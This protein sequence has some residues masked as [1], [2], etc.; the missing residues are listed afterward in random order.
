MVGTTPLELVLSLGGTRRGD[1][2]DEEGATGQGQ[3]V[4]EGETREG[5][6]PRWLVGR[7]GGCLAPRLPAH[8]KRKKE[9]TVV[10]LGVFVL[11]LGLP[12]QFTLVYSM[13]D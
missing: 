7:G 4:V 3:C 8:K 13:A 11:V 9:L 5:E 1:G 6:K 10:E 12:V 2:I